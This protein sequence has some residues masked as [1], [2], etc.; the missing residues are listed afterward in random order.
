MHWLRMQVSHARVKSSQHPRLAYTSRDQPEY[1]TI[2]CRYKYT[3]YHKTA[4]HDRTTPR[5]IKP[6]TILFV[7]Q[8]AAT[9]HNIYLIA[10]ITICSHYYCHIDTT[11]T[12]FPYL[13]IVTSTT[14]YRIYM[15]ARHSWC[16]RDFTG[17]QGVGKVGKSGS[18]VRCL[19]VCEWGRTSLISIAGL[20]LRGPGRGYHTRAILA[21]DQQVAGW[22]TPAI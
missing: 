4:L 14:N 15:C 11:Q 1:H 5:P 16:C 19:P 10:I 8:Y 6:T 18:G 2:L 7:S 13:N 22:R 17:S 9:K 20:A 21:V 12:P 3:I